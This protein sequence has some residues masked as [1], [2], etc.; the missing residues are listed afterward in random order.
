MEVLSE[1]VCARNPFGFMGDIIIIIIIMIIIIRR[2]IRI[3]KPLKSCFNIWWFWDLLW[4]SWVEC[5]PVAWETG[6]QSQVEFY[7]RL[8]KWYVMP[9]CL[10]LSI[11]WSGSRLK[12]SNPG[13][14]AASSP[15]PWCSSYWKGSLRVAL[16]YSHQLYLYSYINSWSQATKKNIK[17][18]FC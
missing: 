9:P 15:T 6:V 7:Q 16:N 4:A 14:E 13:K 10:T 1:R 11:I 3:E 8:K 12:W 17:I 5:L 18:I 2:R